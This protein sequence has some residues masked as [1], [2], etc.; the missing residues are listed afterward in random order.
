MLSSYDVRRDFPIEFV[1]RLITC[2]CYGKFGRVL[3]E[4]LSQNDLFIK[5]DVHLVAFVDQTDLG[6]G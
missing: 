4:V 6:G 1:E 2:N 5:G 3:I